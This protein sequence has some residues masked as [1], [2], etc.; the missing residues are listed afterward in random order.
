ML[1]RSWPS[2]RQTRTPT[3][4]TRALLLLPLLG[5]PATAAAATAL[6]RM[7][8]SG[9]TLGA[10][11]AATAAPSPSAGGGAEEHP[12]ERL[13]RLGACGRVA[14]E[15]YE[16][17]LALKLERLRALFEGSGPPPTPPPASNEDA[18]P[19]SADAAAAAAIAAAPVP[20]PPRIQVFRSA[21]AHYRMRAEFQVWVDR[22]SRE[23]R[24]AAA[25]S[26]AA[27]AA[28][29]GNG[30]G[31][32][33]GDGAAAANGDGATAAPAAAD[34][35]DGMTD[36]YFIM[37][38][39][40]AVVPTSVQ[41]QAGNDGDGD[42]DGGVSEG[43]GGGG[44]AGPATADQQQQQASGA[45]AAGGGRE[46]GD[47]DGAPP[48]QKRRRH[49]FRRRRSER[50][51]A[52]GPAGLGQAAPGSSDNQPAGQQQQQ[53]PQQFRMRRVRI[54]D[55]PA[56]SRLVNSLMR[57]VRRLLL[58]SE[59]L[60]RRLFQVNLHTTL[61]GRAMVTMVYHRTLDVAWEERARE[62]RAWL[63][64][65][66]AEEAEAAAAAVAA[67]NGGGGGG[68]RGSSN[69]DGGPVFCHEL[70]L[71]GRCRGKRIDVERNWVEEEME[72]W[73][74]PF[75]QEE[76]GK[77][78]GQTPAGNG[79]GNGNGNGD[80]IN[81]NGDG[82]GHG[83]GDGINGNGDGNGHGDGA[84]V[85]P[86][87]PPADGRGVQRVRYRQMEM[88]FSQPNAGMCRQMLG[89]ALDVT[90]ALAAA[91]AA[92]PAAA[93]ATASAPAAAASPSARPRAGAP[94][95]TT[96]PTTA[97]TTRN[98]HDLLELYCGNGN[99]SVP[100]AAN[101]RRV[102]ATE[103][104]S[105]AVEAARHNAHANGL[106]PPPPPPA[107]GDGDDGQP[108]ATDPPAR[109][110][111]ARLSAEE[112]SDTWR[113][114]APRRRL[115]GLEVGGGGGLGGLDLRTVLVDP[116]RAGL[117][118]LTRAVILDPRFRRVVY[119]SCNPVT[120]KRD[121]ALLTS[122]EGVASAWAAG[123]GGSGVA[124]GSGEAEERP[125]GAEEGAAAT[126]DGDGPAAAARPFLAPPPPPYRIE[127]FAAFDQ[128]PYT[129]H[130]ECGAYLVRSDE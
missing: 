112:F 101:F 128:F 96:T 2:I 111:V 14:P 18:P 74:L 42:G 25:A 53:Q 29:N 60:R 89:W 35:D 117:D 113:T 20:L 27:A 59:P 7:A 5:R 67:A 122:V 47:G 125:G 50:A 116:P 51:S 107:N 123:G 12:H 118:D 99:F 104:S 115:E 23:E 78:G 61:S 102:L 24:A 3:A 97:A 124:G 82:N 36:L 64:A 80:G 85:H 71:I 77:G 9:A 32:G 56:G 41:E 40:V 81:G 43:G 87:Q 94:D 1:R 26:A 39:R 79:D 127:R 121:L 8:P 62:G 21:P 63:M 52:S 38:E 93:A 66:L 90:A 120:L 98:D 84:N 49:S 68:G 91:P 13:L 126:N 110:F 16:D 129:E 100:L 72:V 58:S 6:R 28:A 92:P 10:A 105:T 75:E 19:P 109:L 48:P 22:P 30:R 31:D 65:R 114:G 57:L 55:F 103:V 88:S 130:L 70:Q 33:N 106:G 86:P 11:A 17:Q 37:H 4:S 15:H 54:D 83:D 46:A 95:T 44:E 108:T 76:D 73:P 69:G 45:G 34:G 119:V